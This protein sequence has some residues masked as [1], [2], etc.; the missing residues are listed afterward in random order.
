MLDHQEYFD[1]TKSIRGFPRHMKYTLFRQ[2]DE[3]LQKIHE[4]E[5]PMVFFVYDDIKEKGNRFYKKGKYREAVEHY[6]YV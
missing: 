2:K 5:F 1:K 6:T 3:K 4:K